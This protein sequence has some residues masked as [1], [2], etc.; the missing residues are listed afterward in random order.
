M[1]FPKAFRRTIVD[2]FGEDGE[3]W[4]SRLPQLIAECERRWNLRVE[5]PVDSLSYNYVCLARRADGSR[6]V[7]KLGVP[8]PEL[9]SEIAAL[10]YYDGRGIARLYASD[11]DSGALLIEQLKPGTPLAA[12]HDDERATAIAAGVMRRLWQPAPQEQGDFLSVAGWAQGIGGLRARF[13]GGSGPLPGGLVDRAE[14]LFTELLG[15]AEENFLLHG[16]FHHFNILQAEREPWL[17]IDPKGVVGERAYDL[18]AFLYNPLPAFPK[19]PG[20]RRIL[21]RRIDQLSEILDIDR[22]RVLAYG[23][24]QAVLSACWSVEAEGYGW[25][26]VITV[27]EQLAALG[28]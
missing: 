28:A 11:A 24:A 23:L 6:A 17:A 20:L 2:V 5:R 4:L 27:A 7:L 26:P 18:G 3:A 10:Q 25:E 12:L 14:R 8:N 21:S 19:Q 13:G 22:Q 16:D 9:A 1:D 15:S